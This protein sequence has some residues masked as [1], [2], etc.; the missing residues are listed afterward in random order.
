MSQ[1]KTDL[2]KAVRRK[3]SNTAEQNSSVPNS[4][5]SKVRCP[6]RRCRKMSPKAISLWVSTAVK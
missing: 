4:S 1:E 5:E 2:E 6:V 3:P